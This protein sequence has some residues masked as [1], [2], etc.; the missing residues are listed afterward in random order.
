V[1]VRDPIVISTGLPRFL[2]PGDVSRVLI[3]LTHVD[4]PP[5]DITLSW[6]APA[7][8]IELDDRVGS[9]ALT[10]AEKGRA[11]VLVPLRALS[12]GDHSLRIGLRT[13]GGRRLA[14]RLTVPVRS[15]VPS[16]SR[17]SVKTLRP[18]GV[19]LELSSG[20]LADRVTGTGSVLVSA[21]DAGRLD[22]PALLHDLDRYPY[23]CAEQVTSRALP[24]LYLSQVAAAAGVAAE[25]GVEPRVR[26]AVAELLSKQSSSGGFG[27][28]GPGAGDFW[29]DAYV[30]DFL[31]RAAGR[32]YRV[33]ES[34]KRMALDN[35]RNRLSYASDFESGGEDVA[36]ALYVL[37]RNARAVIGDLRYYA[38]ARLDAFATPLAKAQVGAALSLYGDRQRADSAF[39]AALVHLERSADGDRWRP[40]YGS[41]LRDAAALLSLAVEGGGGTLDLR[42]LADRVARERERKA[43]TSTQ[44]KAWLL[45][46]AHAL[47]QGP[48]GPQLTVGGQIVDGP[49]FRRFRASDI[50][51][52]PVAIVNRGD[53]PVEAM[54]T[55]TGVPLSPP[56]AGG[57]GYRIERSYYD[58]EG[59]RVRPAGVS[60]GERLVAVISVRADR[61]R[62]ARLIVDDPLPAGFEIDNPSLVRA[63]DLTGIP[64]LGLLEQTSHKEFRADRF[65]AAV[66]RERTDRAE[67]QLAYL[68]RA[69]SPGTFAHPA[70]TVEDMYRP[71]LRG[72]TGQGVV[73]VVGQVR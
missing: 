29:L 18:G 71:Q 1:L 4:G 50:A 65:V 5:G 63:G 46:A 69:V 40:D 67:F 59:R 58:L 30:T 51:G 35:L 9:R 45:L 44:E 17:T 27:L 33:P 48:G 20:M 61:R 16:L 2:A 15:N 24:L 13:P 60:Q 41:D 19:G 57:N 73:E 6:D 10:L 37:A 42:A 26:E 11:R 12:I 49:L 8:G 3:D 47:M 56:P 55:V 23:G 68:V 25:E 36:Y 64:W 53:R 70:A 28:W 62:A 38:E 72:W 54:V 52:H 7:G 39:R 66:E 34:A 31:T 43:Y 32:G 21:S 14:K 22:V